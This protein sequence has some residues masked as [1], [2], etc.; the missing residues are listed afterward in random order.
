M[1][2]IHATTPVFQVVEP[3]TASETPAPDAATKQQHAQRFQ[4]GL[5]W[6]GGGAGLL[7]L[8]F[9]INFLLFQLGT[10]F[11]TPMYVLTSLGA[12]GALKGMADIFGA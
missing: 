11:S 8:S 12:L 10:D 1:E 7:V 4:R 2:P 3:S 9:G 5:L 6:M